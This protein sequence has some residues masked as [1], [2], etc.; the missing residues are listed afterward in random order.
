MGAAEHG[1][2]GQGALGTPASAWDACSCPAKGRVLA[3]VTADTSGRH[4][5]LTGTCA[6]ARHT[7]RY[8]G[9][10]PQSA[11]GRA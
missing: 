5:A 9:G 3:S 1:R 11:V 7:A 6:L 2:H 10:S 4:D 8:G